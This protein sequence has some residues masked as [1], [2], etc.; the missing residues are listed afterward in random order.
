MPK[1]NS[2]ASRMAMPLGSF[3][4]AMGDRARVRR[5]EMS[6]REL[7]LRRKRFLEKSGILLET[8]GKPVEGQ[9]QAPS[10][11]ART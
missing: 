10:G 2:G 5:Q 6:V 4:G 1:D 9:R 7:Y 8:E 3:G 11:A